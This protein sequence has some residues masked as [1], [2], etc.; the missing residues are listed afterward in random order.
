MGDHHLTNS[1]SEMISVA[2]KVA[3]TRTSPTQQT[4]YVL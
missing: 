4:N 1:V 2:I 3:F